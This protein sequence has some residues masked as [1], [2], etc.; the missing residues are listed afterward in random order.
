MRIYDTISALDLNDLCNQLN[1]LTKEDIIIEFI[2]RVQPHLPIEVLYSYKSIKKP[3]MRPIRR[4]DPP[5]Y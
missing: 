1:K 4:K 5:S 3:E 2:E